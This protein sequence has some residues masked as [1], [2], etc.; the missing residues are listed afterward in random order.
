MAVVRPVDAVSIGSERIPRRSVA[1]H[2]HSISCNVGISAPSVGVVLGIVCSMI[3]VNRAVFAA[4]A[5]DAAA[6]RGMNRAPPGS[7][8]ADVDKYR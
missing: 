2:Q 3:P 1:V 8:H 6:E 4:I 7:I 5:R